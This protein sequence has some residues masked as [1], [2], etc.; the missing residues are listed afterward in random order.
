LVRL[1][2]INI[3]KFYLPISY[4]KGVFEKLNQFVYIFQAIWLAE[5]E[6][7][8]GGGEAKS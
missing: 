7:V 6:E 1:N 5:V 8:R 3:L 2:T 4:V